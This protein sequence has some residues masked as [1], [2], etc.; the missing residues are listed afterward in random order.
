V[1]CDGTE[2]LELQLVPSLKMKYLV[3]SLHF[4]VF[5]FKGMTTWKTI[6]PNVFVTVVTEYRANYWQRL[7]IDFRGSRPDLGS[8]SPLF[9]VYK[10]HFHRE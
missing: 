1:F 4:K 3:T 8:A 9:D 7:R 6:R 10:G 2:M 5:H